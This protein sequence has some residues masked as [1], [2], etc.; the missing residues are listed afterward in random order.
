MKEFLSGI[1]LEEIN[2]L[3]QSWITDENIVALI[4]AQEK[5]GIK[6]PTEQQVAEIIKS[7]KTKKIEAYVDKVSDAPLLQDQPS[8]TTVIKRV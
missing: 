1:T 2:K 7:I 8:P 5:E 6:V 3:G 4:T